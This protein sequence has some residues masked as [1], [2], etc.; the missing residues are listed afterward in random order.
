MVFPE[1]EY[2]RAASV[3]EASNLLVELGS[4][5]KIMAGGTD[6][7]PP[8]KDKALKPGYLVDIKNIPDLDKIDYEENAGFRI[9]SLVKL[10][11]IQKNEAINKKN[12]AVADAAH[13]VASRQVRCKGTMVGN[14][15][16]ASPSAD[17]APILL[18]MN[19]TVKTFRTSPDNG[20]SIPI[21]EFFLGVKRT[22]LSQGEIVTELDIPDLAGNEYA[23]YVK[24]SVRKAMDLAIVGVAVW[25]RMDGD[26]IADCRLALGGVATTPIR[27]VKAEKVLIGEKIT[28]EL[29]EKA[30]TAASESCSPITDVRASAEYRKDMIR[31]FTKRAIRK[32]FENKAE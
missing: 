17:T 30:G 8:M 20:R 14:I 32:A 4:G 3:E 15:C 11:A 25:I 31:V 23:A 29:L 24:H 7:M 6:I 21:D 19:T 1:F 9:G 13:Y 2:I 28:D 12:R 22:V 16:N 26:R 18:A 5:A 27:S 10:Y